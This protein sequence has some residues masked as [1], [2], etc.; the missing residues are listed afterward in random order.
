MNKK[1]ILIVEDEAVVPSALSDQLTELGYEPVARATTGEQA[2]ILAEQLRPDLALMDVRLAGDLDGIATAQTIRE[3]FSI[4]VVFLSAYVEQD[5][6]DRA[7]AAQPYGYLTK[8]FQSIELR[9]AID[10]ALTKHQAETQMRR[11]HEEHAAILRTAMDGFGMVD[12]EGRILEVNDAYCRMTGYTREELLRMSIGELAADQ[13][14]DEISAR[15]NQIKQAGCA[16]FEWRHRC[17]DGCVCDVEVSVQYRPN[18]DGRMVAFV[19][20]I[21][22]RKRTEDHLR[23]LLQRLS[24]HVDHS[25]LAVIEWGPD[26]RL[27]RWSGEA[28]RMFGWRAEEV[29]GKHM[30]DFLWICQEDESQVKEVT[31]ELTTGTNPRRFSANRN[32]R[33]DGSIAYCNW[34]NSSLLDASGKMRSILSLVL[35]VTDRRRAEAEKET[36]EV[37]NRQLQKSESLGRMAGAIAH[38]FNNKLAA[39]MMNLELATDTLPSGEVA[40]E[41]LTQAMRAA[42]QAAEVCGLMLTYLGCT[43]GKR[44]PLDLSATCQRS[45]SL[46]RAAMPP[47]VVLETH[48]PCPG[49]AIDGDADQMQQVLTNLVTNAWEAIGDAQG[50]IRLTVKTVSSEGIPAASRFPIDWQPHDRGYACLEVADTGCGIEAQDFEQLFDP[51]FTRK[52]L[53]RGLGLPVILGIARAYDGAVTVASEPGRGSEFR[54]FFPVSEAVVPQVPD[55]A[56]P[57]PEFTPGGTM[58]LVE[59]EDLLLKAVTKMLTHFGFA[60]LAAKDGVEAVDIFWQHREKIR[61]VLCGLTMPRMDGWA[62]LTALRKLAPGI[63]VILASGY[64]KA[65]VMAGNHPELPQAFLSKPYEVEKLRNTLAQVLG[66][67]D[68]R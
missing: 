46:L 33:K 50:T 36:L 51:F 8:P 29:L 35:D 10:L 25:P 23:E 62:T 54:V 22:E 1:R 16:R 39:V 19:R 11:I 34:Y 6:L 68:M 5:I 31:T 4:P 59:D 9:M 60:V 65:Q 24:Y 64:S 3:R 43:L 61:C 7:K 45:L 44:G 2:L 37:Q 18:E 49:P 57:D 13:S 66:K 47:S 53:G 58:L 67:A 42:R 21:T 27:T 63:P 32:Y 20:D 26:M 15:I 41:N 30:E 55:P 38:H 52:F 56:G 12:M 48:L 17:K 14:S 40:V 28:E